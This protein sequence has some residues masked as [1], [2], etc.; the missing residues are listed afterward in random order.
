MK[1]YTLKEINN[2]VNVQNE[3]KHKINSIIKE[4]GF[5]TWG[6]AKVLQQNTI[7]HLEQWVKSGYHADMKWFEKNIETR[8]EI[9]RWYPE[10]KS[11]IVLAYPYWHL[12]NNHI[13]AMYAHGHDYHKIINKKIKSLALYLSKHIEDFKFKISVDSSPVHEKT[14]AVRAGIGWQGKNSLIIN[15][16]IGSLFLLGILVTNIYLNNTEKLENQCGECNLCVKSCP[17]G[18]IQEEGYIDCRKCIS[19][20]TI[21]NKDNIPQNIQRQIKHTIFGCDICQLVCPWNQN[22]E[23]QRNEQACILN[24]INVKDIMNMDETTFKCFFDKTPMKKSGINRIKRNAE[25]YL[26]NRE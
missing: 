25:I 12:C 10:A 15:P 22:I 26:K 21:E 9:L 23:I 19:Y 13:I 6:V 3:I 8:I 24:K 20:H 16:I 5:V 18:A 14:W 7:L 1:K 2:S 4:M 11:V 17:T